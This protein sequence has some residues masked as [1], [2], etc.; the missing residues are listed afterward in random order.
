MLFSN[1]LD[2][3]YRRLDDQLE[4]LLGERPARQVLTTDVDGDRDVD[5][6]V[7]HEQPPHRVVVNDRLWSYRAADDAAALESAP[8]V[9][10]TA[11]DINADGRLDLL[12]LD[13]SG[14]LQQWQRDTTGRWAMTD[15]IA[16]ATPTPRA[17]TLLA[18]DFTGNGQDDVLVQDSS[19]FRL[20]VAT[21][22]GWEAAQHADL[23]P[24]AEL[25]ALQPILLN[26]ADGPALAGTVQ[27]DGGTAL[28]LW[29]AGPGRHTFLALDPTGRS[30]PG[31]GI[32]SNPSGI[33]TGVT[34]RV[35]DRWTLTDRYDR[36]SAPGASLQPLA[37]GLG[38]ARRAD[39]VR[40]YWTDGVL[41]TE[42]A[43]DAGKVHEIAENQRQLASCPVLFAWN[44]ERFDFVSDVLGV[45][46]I[47]FFQ[48]PGRYSE[49]R[50]WEYFAFPD[51]AIAP[52]DGRYAI[53][54]G[55]PMQEIAYLDHAR[56][57]IHDLDPAWGMTLNERMHTGGG[58]APDGRPIYYRRASWLAPSEATN[59][60]G[61]RVTTDLAATDGR[62]AP[63][64]A[65]D[66][67][68]LGRL[69]ADH[70]LTL[71]FDA[72]VNP[73]GTK[74]VLV[75]N[76]W[77]EYPYSQTVFAAWQADAAYRPPTLEAFADG[78]WHTVHEA[79]GYPAGMPREM[80]M[81]LDALPAGTTA[82]RLRS[83]WEI[84]WDRIGIV[85]EETPPDGAVTV[86]VAPP[87]VARLAMTGFARRDTLPQ[88]RPYYDYA[89]RSPFWDTEYA[90][91]HYTAL[92]PVKP[93]VAATDDAFALV[94]PG[95]E[96]HLEF[97]APA[98]LEDRQRI[99]VLEVR[100]YAKDMDL[101]TLT[102]DT[103]GP[104]PRTPGIDDPSARDQLHARFL[105]RWKDGF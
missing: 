77:V 52:R 101:Y 21:P 28:W 57:H 92:G 88:R 60:R 78:R 96:L 18:Q 50:P 67:R 69:A 34:L 44:G 76:G 41:Q 8:L 46:G 89:D 91:G 66:P 5:F 86:S 43:L 30:D 73:A 80:A 7:L 98:A 45:A 70:V 40:L 100:G 62:A 2:G 58:P 95:E 1:N 87:R 22:D 94:G 90:G 103:V 36:G 9:A 20:Y 64:G 35:A 61:E 75:A 63:P 104:L 11:S 74:P 47:G 71:H 33:G 68:F 82:L 42:M 27:Q 72:P 29:T 15:A 105:T 53:K 83:N 4:D 14:A 32:R 59:D 6:V 31:E 84:Y 19:G 13:D 102:G 10:L 56:L 24:G 17:A 25:G 48:E 51:G 79:F 38:G 85:H 23:P 12:A 26:A 39:F 99:V 16:D 97:E 65:R 49:P 3:S 81:P 54:I 37:I 93:L 55:E